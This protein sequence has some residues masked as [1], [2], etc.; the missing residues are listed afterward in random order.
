MRCSHFAF[1]AIVLAIGVSCNSTSS[2][3]A[4]ADGKAVANAGV[5]GDAAAKTTAKA[6]V[7]GEAET[8]V[9]A[10]IDAKVDVDVKPRIGGSIVAVGDFNVEIL[11]FVDGRIEAL[12]M[13]AKGEL[14]ADAG[15]PSVSV[16]LAAAADAR[17]E[18]DLAW[19]VELARFV[20]QLDA[21]IELVPGPV[22]VELTIDGKA[23]VG[24]L[25]ELAIAAHATHGGQIMIAGA[26][27]I[28][29]A[30][31]A[32]VVHAYAF[33]VSG[34]AHAAG[35]LDID[36]ALDAATNLKLKWDPPSA[37]YKADLAA[38]FDLEAKPLILRVAAEGKLAVAAVQS[39]HASAKVAAGGDLDA[40]AHVDAPTLAGSAGAKAHAKAHASG[41]VEGKS[42]GSVKVE[43]KKSSSASGKA[44]ADAGGG[45]KASAK[46]KGGFKLGGS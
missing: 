19:D 30:A 6:G 38:D 11:A 26:Y 12:V 7:A 37:S 36:L 24:T 2:E 31:E 35:D 29:L 40:S 15:K 13:D 4:G 17:A 10:N 46:A 9:D 33:D 27:S 20:G 32:G 22:E 41:G 39:F 43:T 1:G 45:F 3:Q 44:S 42:K 23:S 5:S 8:K 18:V 28:E 34:K 16:T 21:G 14:L 25:A